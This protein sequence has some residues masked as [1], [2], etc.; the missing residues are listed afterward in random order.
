MMAPQ[1]Y[2]GERLDVR[3]AVQCE[4]AAQSLLK[5]WG[6]AH[7]ASGDHQYCWYSHN[8]NVAYFNSAVDPALTPPSADVASVCKSSGSPIYCP[9]CFPPHPPCNTNSMFSADFSYCCYCMDLCLQQH[10]HGYRGGSRRGPERCPCACCVA[11]IDVPGRLRFA[12]C[13]GGSRG[14]YLG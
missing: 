10:A 14:K 8:E 3:T 6:G 9:R 2:C 13:M 11:S 4:G 5:S 7:S 12:S 1:V